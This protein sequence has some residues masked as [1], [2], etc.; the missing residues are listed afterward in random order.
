MAEIIASHTGKA[1]D[2]V[3]RD[4]DRD[5]FMTPEEACDYG[6]IDAILPSRG[7]QLG[8]LGAVAAPAQ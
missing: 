3:M 7:A 2:Q 5:H 8:A 6:L 1:F 4:I